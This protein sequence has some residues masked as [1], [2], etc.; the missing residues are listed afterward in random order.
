MVEERSGEGSDAAGAATSMDAVRTYLEGLQDRIC[1]ALEE[2]D[3]DRLFLRGELPGER[4]GRARPRVL[5]GGQHIEKTAVMFSHTRGASLPAAATV[6]RP[7]L[8]GRAFEAVSVSLI[9]HPRN[10]FAPTSHANVRA[11][12]ASKSGEP[13]V[14]WFGGGFDLTPIYGFDEDCIHWHET[15]KL[16]VE[17]VVPGRYREWKLA[18]DAYFHLPHRGEP[19]GIGGI[20]YDDQGPAELGSF[21]RG[22]ALMRSVADAYIGAYMPLLARRKLQPFGERERDFQL[23]R[24]GRYAEFNLAFDRGTRFGLQAGSRAESILA[25]LPPLCT[26]RYDWHPEPNTPEAAL[27]E[28]Y[29]VPRDWLA[30]GTPAESTG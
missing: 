19:R 10:P 9:V 21:E 18:C 30:L 23:Y 13:A 20:F 5:E 27:Y 25:S 8:A 16:A 7:E 15:A 22:F 14:W 12:V 6:R 11:F 17:T 24:R 4:G 1:G 2:Q 29:L 28:R 3:S 26:W